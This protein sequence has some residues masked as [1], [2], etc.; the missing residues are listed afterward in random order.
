MYPILRQFDYYK[1]HLLSDLKECYKELIF[2]FPQ[3]LINI[4]E[5]PTESIL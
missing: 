3:T 5:A 4:F 2:G 1:C